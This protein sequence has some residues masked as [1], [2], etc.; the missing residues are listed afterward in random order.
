[1]NNHYN[2]YICGVGGQGIIKTSVI[3]GE[4]AMNQGLNVVM[5]EIHGMS[6]L[7]LIHI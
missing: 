1:M 2:I 7:S 3:I 5:S 4:A 6:Q